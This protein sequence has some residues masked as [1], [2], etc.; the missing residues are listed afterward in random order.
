MVQVAFDGV[1]MNASVWINGHLLG[2][3]PY[4]YTPFTF[5]LTQFLHIAEKNVIAVRVDNSRQPSSRWY[6]GS[7]I[8]RHAA[9]EVHNPPSP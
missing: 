8:Y 3:H 7:G 2:T 1:Y 6:T 9:L 4:G 5:D